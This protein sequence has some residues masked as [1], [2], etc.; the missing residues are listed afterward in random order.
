MNDA[1]TPTAKI[2]IALISTARLADVARQDADFMQV[3]ELYRN[4][5]AFDV[6][7]AGC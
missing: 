2:D 3:G 7:S 6:H 1:G 4:D 5:P